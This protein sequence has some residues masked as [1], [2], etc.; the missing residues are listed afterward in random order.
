MIE[1]KDKEKRLSPSKRAEW[2][3]DNFLPQG[4]FLV[5]RLRKVNYYKIDFWSVRI[6]SE[7]EHAGA[8]KR[9]ELITVRIAET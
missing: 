2:T 7:Q 5:Q 9:R 3:R 4:L 8:Y 1:M 6:F